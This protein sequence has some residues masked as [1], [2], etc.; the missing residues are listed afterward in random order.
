MIP[1]GRLI[2]LRTRR[3]GS[4]EFEELSDMRQLWNA[5]ARTLG[6]LAL[7][8]TLLIRTG[9]GLFHMGQALAGTT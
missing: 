9:A 1:P 5:V 7:I 6:G 3:Y 2:P 4:L 8:V